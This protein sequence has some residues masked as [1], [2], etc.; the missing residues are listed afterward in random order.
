MNNEYKSLAQI[1]DIS[2]K[3]FD[4]ILDERFKKLELD[5]LKLYDIDNIQSD[6]L[7]HLA[8][9]YH[10]TGNEGWLQA[11]TEEKK[12]TLIKNAIKFHRFRGTKYSILK[13][14]ESVGYY[15]DLY[16]WFEYDG[17][18]FYFKINIYLDNLGID[19]NI[20]NSLIDLVNSYK[21]VRSHFEGLNSILQNN[22]T[23]KVICVTSISRTLEV[24]PYGI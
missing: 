11:D 24:G 9:Q 8:L 23:E 5:V 1:N 15:A 4:E 19:L 16:E 12:R 18:P 20:R 7:P 6:V 2:L 3:A 10:M 22:I 17:N 21:N 14:L 13:A